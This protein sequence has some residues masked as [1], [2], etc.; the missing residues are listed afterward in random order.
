MISTPA[1]SPVKKRKRDDA[2][3]PSET[4]DPRKHRRQLA[5]LS[6]DDVQSIPLPTLPARKHQD[7][8]EFAPGA[9]SMPAKQQADVKELIVERF[10]GPFEES[11]ENKC[12]LLEPL[13]VKKRKRY[14]AIE[15]SETNDPRKRRRRSDAPLSDDVMQ[16]TPLPSPLRAIKQDDIEEFAPGATSTPVKQQADVEEHID[17]RF[18][19]PSVELTS[20]TEELDVCD[21]GELYID[22]IDSIDGEG[23]TVEDHEAWREH[24]LQLCHEVFGDGEDS[25]EEEAGPCRQPG[26]DALLVA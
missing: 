3:E 13:P 12:V 10:N 25:D 24:Y 14:D 16:P 23:D 5:P 17:E 2:I 1:G 9:T 11:K 18:N 19:S 20:T 15:P 7:V 26:T 6:D 8:E 22:T 21:D 4:K